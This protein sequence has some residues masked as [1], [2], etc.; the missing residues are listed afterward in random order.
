MKVI[1]VDTRNKR[2][3]FEVD[4][5]ENVSDFI[6]RLRKLKGI[7]DT[8]S[9]HANGQILEE[10]QKISDYDIEENTVLIYTGIFRGGKVTNIIIN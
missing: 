10:D 1:I 2:E 9:L 6:E 5:N 4:Q 8:F 3:R 7:N